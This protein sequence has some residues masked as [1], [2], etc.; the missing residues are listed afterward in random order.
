[1]AL[2]PLTILVPLIAAGLLAATRPV[3]SR[4]FASPNY[5]F[6]PDFARAHAA[7]R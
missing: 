5:E 2:I 3:S 1:M 6:G 7:Y 4:A